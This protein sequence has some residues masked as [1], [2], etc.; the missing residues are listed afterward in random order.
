[1][2]HVRKPTVLVSLALLQRLQF[3]VPRSGGCSMSY[4]FRVAFW[5]SSLLGLATTLAASE[6]TKEAVLGEL[7]SLEGTWTLESANYDGNIPPK[8]EVELFRLTIKGDKYTLMRG[9]KVYEAGTL[10][11]D[12]TKPPKTIKQL[13]SEG[14][15]KGETLVGIY[16]LKGDTYRVC[17]ARP[18]K[19]PP[20]KFEQQAG[21]GYDEWTF[22]RAKK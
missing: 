2:I 22:K 7:K 11:V 3:A 4:H 17:R 1:M 14:E 12:P 13:P 6:P 8:Q 19:E 10:I 9:D 18:G 16:E 20:A 5:A 21:A 15:Q